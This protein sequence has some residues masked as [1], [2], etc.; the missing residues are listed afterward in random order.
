MGMA[1]EHAL[2]IAGMCV[3]QRSGRHLTGQTQ[4]HRVKPF[5]KAH[6]SFV[7]ERDLLQRMMKCRKKIAD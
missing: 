4:P 1:A 2:R 7:S 3:R 5:Q 6:D